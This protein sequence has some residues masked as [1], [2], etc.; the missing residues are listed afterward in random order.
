VNF[1]FAVLQ[2]HHQDDG[3]EPPSFIDTK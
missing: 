2:Q 3:L 1:L